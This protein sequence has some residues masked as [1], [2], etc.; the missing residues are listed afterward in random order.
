MPARSSN[1]RS[2]L[3]SFGRQCDS[4]ASE[5]TVAPREERMARFAVTSWIGVAGYASDE[6]SE[7]DDG[8]G[9]SSAAYPTRE[10]A[11]LR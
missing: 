2:S 7:A 6:V 3:S 4:S 9:T 10:G 11:P 1:I 8:F 5:R